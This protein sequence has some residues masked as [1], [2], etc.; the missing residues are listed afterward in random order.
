MSNFT[1]LGCLELVKKFV[2]WWWVVGGGWW[3]WWWW[4]FDSKSSVSFGPNL[5]LRLW[6]WTWTKLNNK[7]DCVEKTVNS[8]RP[9]II[10]PLL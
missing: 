6:I 2:W 10:N 5:R 9:K 1:L 3:G 4:W 7:N 8:I